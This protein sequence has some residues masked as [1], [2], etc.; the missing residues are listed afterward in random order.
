M[1]QREGR[2]TR[3]RGDLTV[4]GGEAVTL[5]Y[6]GTLAALTPGARA[7]L[8][9]RRAAEDARVRETAASIVQRVRREGDDALRALAFEFDGVSLDVLEVPR[10]R[11]DSARAALAPGLRAALERAA[12]NIARAHAAALPQSGACETE[13][14]VRVGR[15][16]DAFERV[17]VYA[18]GGRARY[19]SSVLMGVV[20]A[21]VTGV[22]EV[23]LCTPPAANGEPDA[24]LLAAA[25]IAGADRVFA[26][27]GAGAI[28]ALAYGTESVPAVQKIVGPGNA[29]VAA[30]KRLV[31]ADGAVA[32]DSPAGPSELVV[33]VDESADADTVALELVAQAEHDPEA[34]AL[35]VVVGA[36]PAAR[37]TA[38]LERAAREAVRSD[39]VRAAL[40][41]RGGVLAA[42][43]LA[44]AL[45]FA[46]AVAPEHLLLAVRDPHAAFASVRDAGAVFLGETSSVAFGDY[47]TGGNHVLP[48]AGFA[49]FASGLG[50]SDFVRWTAWQE[51][52][53]AAAASL[54]AD[55]AALAEA[56]GLPAHAAAARHAGLAAAARSAKCAALPT[57][58]QPV[59]WLDDN[60]SQFG[61]PPA[62][63]ALLADAMLSPARYPSAEADALRAALAAHT[64]FAGDELVTGCGSD[65]VLEMT[66]RALVR[67]GERVAWTTPTFS[68]IPAFVEH[69]GLRDVPVPA[70]AGSVLD[71]PALLADDPALVYVCSPGNPTGARVP[72]AALDELLAGTRGVVILDEAYAEFAGAGAAPPPRRHPRL[73]VTRTFSKAWGLAG[74][75]VGW[76]A[77]PRELIARIAALR[78]PF[79]ISA[80]AE[81]AAVAALEHDALWVAMHAAQ[82]VELRE[83]FTRA[84]TAN[85]FAPLPSHANFV[86]LP[87]RDA[88]AA[89][90]ALATSG[91]RVR[92]FPALEGIGDALRITVAPWPAL[93]RVHAALIAALL[94][95]G[96][97]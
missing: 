52:S 6:T 51:V 17:G 44:E 81:R 4:S 94:V 15:R 90:A 30:A 96:R 89:A 31:A 88:S 13:P 29:W 75:R 66:F 76:A 83:R 73:V 21:R 1:S 32:I 65:D 48:T 57:E 78:S 70:R 43:S 92:A 19:P 50:T 7:T 56:E 26:L 11:W 55:T 40:A 3:G 87:V 79:R 5:R 12:D 34:L 47:L 33:V 42:D 71:V 37:V 63:S 18:P 85:G 68:M 45:A 77:G 64:G 23:I 69:A 20:P 46:S 9:E 72:D 35:A 24:L 54:A 41:A 2:A 95:D 14:G 53:D 8:L 82:A 93:E 25:A 67:P 27:G 97:S 36:S 86:L 62:A 39:V 22:R 91:V 38:A 49:R 10:A 60:T 58:T 80:L 16:P 74:L 84:L 59:L 28:A 61:A